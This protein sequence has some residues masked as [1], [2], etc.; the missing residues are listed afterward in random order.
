M[1]FFG[2]HFGGHLG[3]SIKLVISI[4]FEVSIIQTQMKT[5]FRLILAQGLILRGQFYVLSKFEM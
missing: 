2:G 5:L 4:T 1:G 3:F